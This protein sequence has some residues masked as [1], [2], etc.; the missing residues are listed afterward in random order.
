MVYSLI[1]YQALTP[2]YIPEVNALAVDQSLER[3][4]ST[5]LATKAD[6]TLLRAEMRRCFSA[7]RH[8]IPAPQTSLVIKLG[9][10][11]VALMRVM[12]VALRFS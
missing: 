3:T 6:I 7:I 1:L 10:L 8:E 4:M 5:E 9:M 12:F 2:I 11:V